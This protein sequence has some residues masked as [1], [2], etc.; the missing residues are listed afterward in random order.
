MYTK[1]RLTLALAGYLLTVN[2][3]ACAQGY[4]A[5]GGGAGGAS[6]AANVSFEAGAVSTN[7]DSHNQLL[8]ADLGFIFNADHLPAGTLHYPVPHYDYTSLGNR[9]KGNEY[10]IAGKYGFELFK[11]QGVFVL[12]IGGLSISEAVALAQSNATG[13]YYE[14]ASSTKINGLYGG[15][16]AYFPPNS[17]WNISAEYDNRRGITGMIGFRF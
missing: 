16:L 6:E 10:T 2:Y 13:W 5:L 11:N 1:K 17:R 14:N 15:G 12:G 7:A 3:E 4:V 9:Q 8:A